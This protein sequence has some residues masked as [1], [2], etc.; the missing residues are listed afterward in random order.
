MW[1]I[2]HLNYKTLCGCI[3]IGAWF[4][5]IPASLH[6]SLFSGL[7]TFIN[8]PLSFLEGIVDLSILLGVCFL[9]GYPFQAD[10]I[11]VAGIRKQIE[12]A[13]LLFG[14]LFL[15]SLPFVTYTWVYQ[16]T[17]PFLQFMVYQILC[18]GVTE[19]LLYRGFIRWILQTYISSEAL[20]IILCALLF[21]LVHI[22]SEVLHAAADYQLPDGRSVYSTYYQAAGSFLYLHDCY[23]PWILQCADPWLYHVYADPVTDVSLFDKKQKSEPSLT[24]LIFFIYCL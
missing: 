6:D 10:K 16:E 19:E 8:I 22:G 23:T 7:H 4:F 14:I 11:T 20:V 21:S 2:I 18:I 12:A 15:C 17:M 24:A 1:Q 5:F 3:V 13:I 9:C